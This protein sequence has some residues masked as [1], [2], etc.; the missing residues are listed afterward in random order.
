MATRRSRSTHS[1]ATKAAELAVA[2]PQV[3]AHRVTRMALS[4]PTLSPR[5][6]KEFERMV[7]EKNAAFA[8]SWQ[9]MAT[10]AMLANQALASSFFRSFLSV[11]MGREA[12][13]RG[14]GEPATQGG[15]RRSGQGTRAGPPQG[16]RQ[17]KAPVSHEASMNL[18][19]LVFEK[20]RSRGQ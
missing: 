3:V 5:D 16:R 11:S 17:R 19:F 8:E 2:V 13:P 18:R 20:V 7:A 9:A 4:G 15:A 10:Q 1:L 6:R 12:V 14:S